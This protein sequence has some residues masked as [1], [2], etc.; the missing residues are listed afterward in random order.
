MAGGGETGPELAHLEENTHF[1]L[2]ERRFFEILVKHKEKESSRKVIHQQ[3]KAEKLRLAL[4]RE[5]KALRDKITL[6]EV[7]FLVLAFLVR[8]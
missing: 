4:N 2:V 5:I 7:H 3:L 1:L 8:F 6:L